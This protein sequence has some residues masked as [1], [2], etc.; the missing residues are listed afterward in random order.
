MKI[1]IF[2]LCAGILLSSC[3][4]KS[5]SLKFYTDIPDTKVKVETQG[6]VT[7]APVEKV[8]VETTIPK[9]VKV[10]PINITVLFNFN[11]AELTVETVDNLDRMINTIGDR[12]IRLAIVGGCCPIGTNDFNADLGQ[13]RATAV[14]EYLTG[15][16]EGTFL[17]SSVGET[18]LVSRDPDRYYLNR[19]VVITELN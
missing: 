9:A 14:Y 3:N 6:P 17:A 4:R 8:E 10:A 16:I 12:S 15:K 13:R 18:Q 19:R 1:V 7:P 2:L 5:K 11:S